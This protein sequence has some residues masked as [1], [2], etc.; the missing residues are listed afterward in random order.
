MK[1]LKLLHELNEG[2][3]AATF[4]EILVGAMQKALP[5]DRWTISYEEGDIVVKND[6]EETAIYRMQTFDSN[7]GHFKYPNFP[8]KGSIEDSSVA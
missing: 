8:L 6:F 4:T 3:S 7:E 1:H 5:S 2:I